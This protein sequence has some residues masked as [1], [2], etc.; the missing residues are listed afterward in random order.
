MPHEGGLTGGGGWPNPR[1]S[2]C[3]EKKIVW[4]GVE[5]GPVVPRHD[6]QYSSSSGARVTSPAPP[7][8]RLRMPSPEMLYRT[9]S[10]HYGALTPQPARLRPASA[11]AT[12][13]FTGHRHCWQG[14]SLGPTNGMRHRT[15]SAVPHHHGGKASRG[16]RG[17]RGD[18]GRSAGA[19][20]S[21]CINDRGYEGGVAASWAA[22]LERGLRED[23]QSRSRSSSRCSYSGTYDGS[24]GTVSVHFATNVLPIE[25]RRPATAG[26]WKPSASGSGFD[27]MPGA[28]VRSFSRTFKGGRD[29]K[30]FTNTRLSHGKV[31]SLL[32]GTANA[33]WSPVKSGP[34]FTTG[35]SQHFAKGSHASQRVRKLVAEHRS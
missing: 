27:A 2:S 33:A 10:S 22:Q 19:G 31:S 28:D 26:R 5:F 32:S 17:G 15:A 23:A 21:G 29:K 20:G 35:L 18:R 30:E 4:G 9:T 12:V 6:H 24:Y 34:Y 7:L 1:P 25:R 3:A 16:G 13:G 11:S 8:Q 14:G